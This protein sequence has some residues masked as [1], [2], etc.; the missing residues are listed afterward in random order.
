MQAAGTGEPA[1]APLV[2]D[3]RDA[4]LGCC[5][6]VV[7]G[8]QPVRGPDPGAGWADRDG[9]TGRRG[10]ADRAPSGEQGAR[11]VGGRVR[12][13][14]SYLVQQLLGFLDNAVFEKTI[15]LNHH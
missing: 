8:G 7:L 1:H 11:P 14:I 3:L 15:L 6:G 4:R 12:T 9:P 2:A 13:E 5:A 10:L